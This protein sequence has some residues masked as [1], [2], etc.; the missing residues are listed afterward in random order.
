[1][2]PLVL[3]DDFAKEETFRLQDSGDW[4]YPFNIVMNDGFGKVDLAFTKA[5]AEAMRDW[6]AAS[7][8]PLE[9]K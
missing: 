6:L 2:K 8:A 7:L 9:N 5:E 3:D 1:M 4:Q